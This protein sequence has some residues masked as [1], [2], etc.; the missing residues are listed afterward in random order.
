MKARI[1]QNCSLALILAV[2]PVLWGCSQQANSATVDDTVAQAPDSQPPT[3][4]APAMTADDSATNAD[5]L[6]NADGKLISTPATASTNVSNNP[7]IAGVVKLVQA[8]VGES[9]LMAYVTN[10]AAPFNLSSDDIVYLNDLGA[11]ETVVSAMLQRDQ[12]YAASTPP[13]NGA[14][15]PPMQEQP[16]VPDQNAMA[17]MAQTPPLTPSPEVEQDV[18][19]AANGSYS[20]FYDSLAPYGNWVNIEGYG[21][22]WQPT[23][24]VANPGWQPYSERGH[25]AYTDCGWCWVSDYSWGWAPF[26]YGRWFRNSHFGWCWAPDTVWGPAWVSWR[27]SDS[28][29]GWAPL[30][31]AACYRPGFGFTYYGRS[32]GFNFTFGLHADHF[33]FVGMDHFRER[34]PGRYRVEHREV[35]KIYNT[36][37]INN[38]IIRGNNNT[39]INRGVPVDRVARATH[40][41]IRPIHVRAEADAPRSA[42]LGRDGRTLSVFRPE[43]P[44]PRAGQPPRLVGEDVKPAPNFNLHSRMERQPAQRNPAVTSTPDRRPIVSNPAMNRPAENAGRD[45]RDNRDNRV[46]QPNTERPGSV[47]MR[48]PNQPDRPNQPERPTRGAPPRQDGA[49][50]ANPG[51]RHGPEFPPQSPAQSGRDD[52]NRRTV[53]PP[54]RPQEPGASRND[55]TAPA[56]NRPD[57][58]QPRNDGGEQLRQQRQLQQQQQQQMQQQQREL[59]QQ[60]RQQREIQ[61]QPVVPTPRQEP[62]Q[63]SFEAP[64]SAP[65]VRS[66]PVAPPRVFESRPAPQPS[67][68][69]H[70]SRSD[71]GGGRANGGGGNNGGGNNRDN[72]NNNGNGRNR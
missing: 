3:D 10:S 41:E 26:H 70:E 55:S 49:Q 8:G 37:V 51:L 53:T 29:C 19:Q 15:P 42:Q 2:A 68:P 5:A 18:Q 32:V 58:T 45:N 1:F 34:N 11:P 67:A 46:A 16:S 54:L 7:Q 12:Y 44:K 47:I 6:E 25:W 4:A 48:G 71:N 27:Y 14:T 35:T 50:P 40:T 56:F 31:P 66:E 17:Q 43:L 36:T 21:P 24:V 22:C 13:A 20:Y 39:I 33:T 52:N 30:P 60:Q 65:P 57:T 28:Y 38:Q 61:P 59:Q 23:V 64:R 69:A 72:G 9:V 62:P 63:R